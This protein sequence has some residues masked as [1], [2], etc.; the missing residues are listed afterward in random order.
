MD[1][2]LSIATTLLLTLVNGFFSAAEMAIVSARRGALEADVDEGDSKAQLVIDIAADRG[3]FL[4]TIQVAITLV[5]F[6]SSAFAATS[7]SKPFGAWLVSIGVHADLALPLAV[8]AI[9]LIVSFFSVVIGELVP[10]SIGLANA[11]AVAKAVVGSMKAFMKIARPL[12]FITSAS[13]DAVTRLM[14]VDTT[15]DHQE[16]TEE[17]LRYIVKDSE[18]LSEEE[19]SMIHE[20]IEM[21]DTVVREVMVPRV[22]MT[23]ME[24]TATISEVLRVMRQTGFS[25]IP[26]YHENIDRIVGIAHIK[27]LLETVLDQ[28][29]GDEKI[30]RFVR[31]ADYVP[32][33]K[34]IIPLL[35]E[36]QTSRDQMVIVVDEY[37]GTAGVITVEDIVEEIVGEI[38]DEF[39][40]DNKYLTQL[41]DREW[42]VDGCFSL[43]D[44]DEL[45]WPVGESEEYETIAGFVL[46]LAGHL[47]RPGEVFEKDG[48][49]F[50]VQSMRRRRL[51]LLR[52]IAP[53]PQV[54]GESEPVG[55][56]SDTSENE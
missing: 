37:G 2:A 4:A 8:V 46:D 14:G 55:E 15:N 35:T 28:H 11:E 41:S 48:Y 22:D 38:E 51:S 40:P 43:N 17:E 21:G 52:V 27:D 32:D 5:G 12:V 44:A 47:P 54:D 53:E 30:A 18:D 1:I 56:N 33:T 19:K 31:S 9:T 7:L 36:M 50:R 39:D 24:D 3:Y 23:A 45:G 29:A 49:V 25:R 13:A 6:A 20:V 26:I 10:K 34:D 42:L 16:V